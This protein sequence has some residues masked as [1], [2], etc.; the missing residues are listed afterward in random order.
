[1]DKI[2][3]AKSEAE[4]VKVTMLENA[5]GAGKPKNVNQKAEKPQSTKKICKE[6]AAKQKGNGK[7][8]YLRAN[9]GLVAT[10]LISAVVIFTVVVA[11]LVNKETEG[12]SHSEVH[13]ATEIP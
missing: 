7:M 13:N 11:M 6:S 1:M 2:E 10:V 8:E 4:E 9:K 12:H 5:N 3:T